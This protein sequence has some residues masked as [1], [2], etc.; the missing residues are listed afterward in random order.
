[1]T[2]V[3]CR[4][5]RR[6]ASIPP[7]QARSP[8]RGPHPAGRTSRAGARL[9]G[10]AMRAWALP[11]PDGPS[12]PRPGSSR[13]APRSRRAR[14]QG[15]RLTLRHRASSMA[16]SFVGDHGRRL[17]GRPRG[18]RRTHSGSA[19]GAPSR[20]GTGRWRSRP[21]RRDEPG[22]NPQRQRRSSLPGGPTHR[23]GPA[24]GRPGA[25]LAQ[26]EVRGHI[27]G[28]PRRRGQSVPRDR[29]RRAGR[30]AVLAR[31]RRRTDRPCRRSVAEAGG[32]HRGPRRA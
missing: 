4:T 6:T 19:A 8:R 25:A 27:A 1:M 20:C 9:G 30:R 11:C 28:R 12:G 24:R 5:W 22:E 14:N 21:E 7:Q 31:R 3:T 26:D 15:A 18:G 29:V 16:C 17:G 23:A 13:P 10:P 32:G 2:A